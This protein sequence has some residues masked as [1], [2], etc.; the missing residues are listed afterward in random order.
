MSKALTTIDSIQLDSAV[1]GFLP[2]L[3][4]LYW[5]GGAA[6]TGAAAFFGSRYGTCAPGFLGS[7]ATD[8]AGVAGKQYSNCIN[9][10]GY[11]YP[12][13]GAATQQPA[14]PVATPP[15]GGQN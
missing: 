14:A 12:E 11:S 2:A 15:A 5:A 6:A 4:L 1:G 8:G 7:W 3:P 10:P 9:N 13:N